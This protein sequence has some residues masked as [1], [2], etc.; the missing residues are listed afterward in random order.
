MGKSAFR[1]PGDWVV[2]L[3][4]IAACI[5]GLSEIAV[6]FGAGALGIVY[7]WYKGRQQIG[8]MSVV[9]LAVVT[10]PMTKIFWMYSYRRLNCLCPHVLW[11]IF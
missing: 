7:Q 5:A 4:C 11:H 2:A 9:P 8:A 1:K 3:A 6:L 10:V